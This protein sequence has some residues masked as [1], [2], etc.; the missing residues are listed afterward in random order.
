MACRLS[1]HPTG[2]ISGTTRLI[3][4]FS[5]STIEPPFWILTAAM[6]DSLVYLREVRCKNTIELVIIQVKGKAAGTLI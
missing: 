3:E 2:L 5:D 4:I 6:A 1:Q